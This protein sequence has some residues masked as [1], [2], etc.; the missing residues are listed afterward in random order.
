MSTGDAFF[1]GFLDDYFAES[2]EHLSAAA[3]ALMR[4]DKSIGQP[5]A[6]RAAVDDLF[7]YFHTLKA[8]SAM[9]ELRPAEQL[10][11]HLEHYLRAVREGECTVTIGGQRCAHRGHQAPRAHHQCPPGGIAASTNRGC[12]REGRESGRHARGAPGRDI[13]S[14]RRN[15]NRAPMDMPFRPHPRAARLG[16]RR[17]S[18]TQAPRRDRNDRRSRAARASGRHDQLSVHADHGR[19]RRCRRASRWNSRGS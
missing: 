2:E 12:A 5:S 6:E 10:A 15:R 3:D 7:R 18:C 19:R 8:I 9:V 1:D 16:H 17:R 11:H 13:R 14:R 4:L